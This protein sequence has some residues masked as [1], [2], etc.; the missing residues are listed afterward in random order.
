MVLYLLLAFALC[1]L[2]VHLRGR[3]R[4]RFD[5]Q[6]VDH[7]ALFAPY[8]LLMYA[9][10]AVPARPILDRRGFPQLD[11]LQQNW[12]TIR[13]EALHL[14]DEGY[15]RAAEK[16]GDASFNSFFKQGWKRFY[17]KWY[18]EPMPS[19]M[20]LCPKTVALLNAIPGIK[21][22]MFATLA[23]HSKLN[24][25]R[26]PFAGSLRYHL[27]LIT[28]NS[29]DCRIFVDGE[30]HAWGDG[31]DVVFDETYVHWVEN[32]TDQ[33]R[34]I[35]FADVERPLRTRLM[36]AINH[37]V[38]AFMGKITTSPNTDAE[39]GKTGLVNRLF[40]LNQRNRERNRAFKKKHPK[41][42]R[43]LKYLGIA[44]LIWLIFL[45]PWP[46]VR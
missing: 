37:R 44:L 1:V 11:R 32:K 4:L 31:K 5:R 39:A 10:S 7:S 43:A 34:V 36:G 30:E 40:A 41:L 13:E 9:F 26:D 33:T 27:G 45:A 16:H 21:A 20:A 24:P 22:A 29:R 23:P 12:Q 15:I 6:L 17:L 18:G 14:F 19:A 35:L 46:L 8:N 3:A 28:P 2:L 38:G 25:H 42:F